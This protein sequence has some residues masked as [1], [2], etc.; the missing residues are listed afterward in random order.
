MAYKIL[1]HLIQFSSLL[2]NSIVYT[3]KK[4]SYNYTL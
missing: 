2:I 1:H 3:E 4:K